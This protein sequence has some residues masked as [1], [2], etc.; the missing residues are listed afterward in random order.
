MV[1]LSFFVLP[2]QRIVLSISAVLIY[3]FLIKFYFYSVIY[4][5]V[6]FVVHFYP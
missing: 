2:K 5:I 6:Y 3:D 4:F 1:Q